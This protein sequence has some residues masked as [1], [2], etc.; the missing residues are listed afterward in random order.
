MKKKTRDLKEGYARLL[1]LSLLLALCFH[2]VG[3]LAK[4]ETV[5]HPTKMRRPRPDTLWVFPEKPPPEIEEPPPLERPRREI[6]PAEHDD[7]DAVETI[8]TDSQAWNRTPTM[9]LPEPEF[10]ID[11]EEP[12]VAINKI[13]PVYP[14]MA[15]IGQIEGTVY[16]I[17]YI[18][19]T[20]RVVKVEIGGSIHESLDKA[21]L[22][23]V[24]QW[25]FNP[26]KMR[27]KPVAVMVGIPVTF[28]LK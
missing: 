26:A 3:F 13:K 24:K 14:P 8:M 21:A 17:A 2:I 25:R 9:D 5:L 10:R 6:E 22:E 27:D 18:D 11:Y 28:R 20:G 15:R 23:A 16:V 1:K 19:E 7:P 4:Q 12:P